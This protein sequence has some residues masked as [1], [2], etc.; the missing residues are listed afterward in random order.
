MNR[1]RV[2]S[3]VFARVAERTN[4]NVILLR[5]GCLDTPISDRPLQHI[6]RSDCASWYDPKDQLPELLEGVARQG[7]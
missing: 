6:W 7:P 1:H 5:L 4:Q 3:G 2:N